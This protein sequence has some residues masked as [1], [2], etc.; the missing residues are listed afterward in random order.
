VLA[1]YHGTS[2]PMKIADLQ[3]T[4]LVEAFLDAGRELSYE[5]LDV[6]G[7]SQLGEPLVFN[8][9]LGRHQG[10][11]FPV[12]YLLQCIVVKTLFSTHSLYHTDGFIQYEMLF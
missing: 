10:L 9:I 7:P 11:R 8:F 5:V 4:P 2:G 12:K 6:N 1:G 3:L